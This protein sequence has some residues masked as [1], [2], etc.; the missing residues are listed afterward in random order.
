MLGEPRRQPPATCRVS[1][2]E[3]PQY[4]CALGPFLWATRRS[5]TGHCERAVYSAVNQPFS[6]S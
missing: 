1:K 3:R 5:K 4:N 2:L 6:A